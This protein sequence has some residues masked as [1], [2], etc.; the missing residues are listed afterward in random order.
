MST[1]NDK[2]ILATKKEIATKKESIAKATRFNPETN[3]NLE[4]YGQRYNLNVCDKDTLLM[5]LATLMALESNQVAEFKISGFTVRQWLTDLE[6]KY[7]YLNIK[8]EQKRLE[9]LETKLTALLSNDK[10][11]EL[12]LSALINS[13]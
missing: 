9:D 11:V 5:L 13:I 3:C 7:T 1:K 12:E 10:K 8:T 4:L 2:L 6:A